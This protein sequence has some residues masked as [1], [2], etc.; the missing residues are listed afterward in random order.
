M[1][2][3]DIARIAGVSAGTVS[4]VVNGRDGVGSETRERV[5]ALIDEHGYRASFFAQNLASRRAF[6]IGTV[7]PLLASELVI[8]PVFPELIGAIGDVAA[9]RDYGLMLLTVPAAD[10]NERIVEETSRG[11]LDGII[12]PDVRLGDAELLATLAAR[13]FPTVLV[14]H[15]DERFAWVDCDHDQAVDELVSLLVD[16]GH[17]RIAFINGPIDLSAC[18]LRRDGYR[19]GLTQHGLEHRPEF[20]RDGPFSSSFGLEALEKLLQ[21]PADERP[22]AVIAGSDVIAAGCIEAARRRQLRLPDDLAITGFDAQPLSA[23]V[24]P[25]LTTVRM[26]IDEMGRAA[27]EMLL[28]LIEEGDVRPRTLVLPTETIVRES[29]GQAQRWIF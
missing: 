14:G 1:T 5:L 10:R 13:R 11:R 26:P 2:V 23:L 22:T 25:A 18:V 3:H 8:H 15:R 28:R 12:L 17:E 6:A 4:R 19:R 29:S 27:V 24:E 9:G 16:G 7:F 20:E 21:R